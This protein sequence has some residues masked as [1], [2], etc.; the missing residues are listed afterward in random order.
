MDRLAEGKA[1]QIYLVLRDRI[2]S[3]ALPFGARLLPEPALAGEHGVARITVRRALARLAAE[4]L[5]ERR[6]SAG[7]RVI[8]KP[9]S[10]AVTA[11]IANVVAALVEMGRRTGV[12]LLAFGYREPSA[13][14]RSALGLQTGERTQH[15]VRVRLVDGLPFSYLTTHVPERIGAHYTEAE[16]AEVPLL[17]LLE[18]SGVAVEQAS[19][20]IGAA[21]ATP[22]VAEAL[23]VDVGAPLIELTRIV[24]DR[25]G[26]GVEHLHAFYRP[27]RYSFRMDLRRNQAP[28]FREWSPATVAAPHLRKRGRTNGQINSVQPT[29]SE[30]PR[31]AARKVRAKRERSTRE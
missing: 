1:R 8:Y 17:A 16:L 23:S 29:V 5:V 13:A 18:R 7:T 12:K 26:E 11:D 21:L 15:A 6:R 31:A 22:D 4:G 3:G 27:D 14:V 19:Q 9:A 2:T 30:R 28:G 24:F 20:T 10:P 25:R